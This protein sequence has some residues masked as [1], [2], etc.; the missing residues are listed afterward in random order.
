MG[1]T[2][3]CKRNME[4]NEMKMGMDSVVLLVDVNHVNQQ[5]NSFHVNRECIK[6]YYLVSSMWND[7]STYRLG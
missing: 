2:T 1:Y 7:M 3:G 5:H 4:G 6:D